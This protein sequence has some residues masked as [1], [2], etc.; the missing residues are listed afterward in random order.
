MA[1]LNGIDPSPSRVQRKWIIFW[2]VTFIYCLLEAVCCFFESLLI[3]RDERNGLIGENELPDLLMA[4]L[5][6]ASAVLLQISI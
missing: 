1:K 2:S 3:K 4:T 5:G 6:L